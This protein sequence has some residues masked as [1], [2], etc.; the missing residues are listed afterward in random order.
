MTLEVGI[1]VIIGL[2]ILVLAVLA[3]VAMLVTQIRASISQPSPQTNGKNGEQI[4]KA[5]ADNIAEM[6]RE[7]KPA[8]GASISYRINSLVASTLEDSKNAV[9]ARAAQQEAVAAARTVQD[10]V[11]RL[12]VSLSTTLE[13]LEALALAQARQ[14]QEQAKIVNRIENSG[15]DSNAATLTGSTVGQLSAGAGTT[16]AAGEDKKVVVIEGTLE[17][18]KE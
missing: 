12:A 3:R 9:Y 14:T 2:L 7:F 4:N 15:R 5:M 6:L 10:A 16:Q 17:E 11:G 8:D 18:K 13:K 1:F